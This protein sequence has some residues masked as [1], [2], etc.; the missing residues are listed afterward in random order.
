MDLV[1]G[2]DSSTTATKA[3]AWTRQGQ[4]IAEGR[5][6]VP[7]STPGPGAFEQQPEEWWQA[8]VAAL[9]QLTAKIDPAR[10]AA[11]AI[12]N[13]RE[14]VGFLDAA[15]R[16]LRP[17]ILWLD[18]RCR[19]DVARVAAALGAERLNEITGKMPDLTPALYS[20]AWLQRNEPANF[21]ATRYFVDVQGYLVLRL[22]GAKATSWGS[23][24]PHGLFDL[25]EKKLSP[26]ILAWMGLGEDQFFPA[27]APGTVLG[28]LTA[29]AAA[30]T[31]LR[32][33]TIVA[34]GGGD[35]QAAGLGCAVLGGGRAY[36]NLGTA[37][38]SGVFSSVCRTDPA[39]RTETSLSGDGYIFETCLRTGM[40]LTDWVTKRLFGLDPA[41]D[42]GC[43]DRLEEAAAAV[44][45]GS[46]GLLLLPYWS[47][48]MSPHWNP[49]ARGA[50]VGFAPEHDRGHVYRALIE[51]IALDMAAGYDAIEAL[52]EPVKEIVVIGGGAKSALWRRIFADA[53][54][55]EL[56]ASETV[57]ASSLGA[58]HARGRG[59]RLVWQP[60]RGRAR[61][62]GPPQRATL[63]RPAPSRHL[64]R[65][66]RDLC[67][68][69]SRDDGDL[70]PI[71]QNSGSAARHEQ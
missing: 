45:P 43:Y 42:P 2:L 9:R 71:G 17:A 59:C 34:A 63:A 35:G 67:R 40:F 52:G 19:P 32:P 11:L 69:L 39:F 1:V 38:V 3:V 49:D 29:A 37:V 60:A 51:G 25:R 33:G 20:L 65:A 31:G 15:G 16:S 22:T 61:H 50:M 5:A 13:Q 41:G 46:D 47:G 12:S 10:I 56:V 6:P 55:R 58:G 23:A 14:T 57:E 28:E 62:A 64:S 68:A 44:P 30:A 36:L 7:L 4:A 27:E 24:D 18:E 53:T 8:A 66:R 70:R 26:E 48:V 54:G 21:A